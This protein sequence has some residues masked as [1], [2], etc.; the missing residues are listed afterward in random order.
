MSRKDKLLGHL[1]S[2]PAPRD[3]LWDDLVTLMRHFGYSEVATS[4]SR[5][6][7][8]DETGQHLFSIHKPHPGN[9]LKVYQVKEVIAALEERGMIS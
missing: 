2:K 8:A 3:F 7:F 1:L 5:R 4:G 9:E 6:K